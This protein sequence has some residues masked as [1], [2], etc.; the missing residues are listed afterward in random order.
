[1]YRLEIWDPLGRRWASEGY[2]A[3]GSEFTFSSADEARATIAELRGTG[4]EWEEARFRIMDDQGRV[5]ETDYGTE[6]GG[7]A[8]IADLLGVKQMT[9]HSWRRRHADFP[10]P[11]RTLA[12]GPLWRLEQ[13]AEWAQM[14]RPGGRPRKA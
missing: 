10:A 8:E 2:S 7:T 5:A 12:T 1:M 6:I 3:D 11:W 14:R 4:S 9:V 13:I